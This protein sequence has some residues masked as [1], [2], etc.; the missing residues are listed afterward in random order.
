MSH[1]SQ[2][3]DNAPPE[4]SVALSECAKEPI[5]IPGMIQPHGLLLVLDELSLTIKQA[6]ANTID[7][8]SI[9]ADRLVGRPVEDFLGAKQCAQLKMILR[10]GDLLQGNPLK[11]RLPGLTEGREFDI[12]IHKVDKGV[13]LEAEPTQVRRDVNYIAYNDEIR[14]ATLRIQSTNSEESLWQIACEEVRRI[15]GFDRVIMYRFEPDYCGLVIAESRDEQL[16]TS[17][18]G[19]H[20]PASDIPEQARHLYTVKRVGYIPDVDYAPVGL[21]RDESAAIDHPLDMTHCVLRSVSPV[22][23]EFLQNMGVRATLTLL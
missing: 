6:S 10:N 12:L 13:V 20:F 19:H 4:Y 23:L 3:P 7:L 21:L 22:H 16:T 2:C 8:V 5:R 14:R 15:I 17:Y 18:L 11:M 9:A 1:K